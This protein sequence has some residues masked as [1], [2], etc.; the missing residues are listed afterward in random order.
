MLGTSKRIIVIVLLITLLNQVLLAGAKITLEKAAVSVH[1]WKST[2]VS[3]DYLD[4]G[5]LRLGNW[6]SGYF[7]RLASLF[8]NLVYP[9]NRS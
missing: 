4:N 9:I 5:G 6:N 7:A 1:E 8:H 3:D 2:N